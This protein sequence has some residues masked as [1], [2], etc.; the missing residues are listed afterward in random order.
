M[1]IAILDPFSGISGDMTLGALVAVGLDPDW[2][3]ALPERLGLEGVGVRIADVQRAGIGC[4]KV[5]FDIPPQPHG[6]HLRHIRELVARS[7]APDSVKARADAA[8]TAIAEQEAAI[9]GTTVERVHLH[10]VGAVD[11]IL[12]VVGAVWGFERLGVSRVYCGPISL[13]DGFVDAAHG[14]LPVPAPATLRLLEGLRV[15]PGP[16]D[17]GELVTPTGAAL[18]R[19]LASGPMA[20]EYVPLRSGFGAGTR[21]FEGRPN[22]LRIT[23]AEAA[24][25]GGLAVEQLVQLACDLDDITGEYL[26]GAADRLREGGALDV[27]V[28]PTVMK[29]GRPGF[30][31]EVLAAPASADTLERVMLAET[32]TLGVRRSVV[33]RHAVPREERVVEVAGHAVRVKVAVLADGTRQVK[34]EYEDVRRVALATAR[35]LRTIFQEAAARAAEA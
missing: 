21:E 4:V 27:V 30:R 11:A 22:A 34:P 9:H 24:G 32:T 8:F 26:A 3:R 33:E 28:I 29:K 2:L 35:T 5:D 25:A 19:V 13:G 17:S 23:L 15:R 10:E 1:P 31:L 18:V 20:G 12:D 7:A 6:R 14:R 16:A